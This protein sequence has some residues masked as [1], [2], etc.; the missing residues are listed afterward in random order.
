MPRSC[1]RPEFCQKAQRAFS[2]TISHAIFAGDGNGKPLGLL[3]GGIAACDTV[4]L[5]GQS[6]W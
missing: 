4:P 2:I 1:W 6:L 5:T 3:N